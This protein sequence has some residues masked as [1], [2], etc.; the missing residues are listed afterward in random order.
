MER[1]GPGRSHRK[2]I[3]LAQLF[4]M[5]P[6]DAAAGRWL[7]RQRWPDGIACH[8]CGSTRVQTGAGHRSMPLRCREY[9]TCGKRFSVRTGTVMQSSKL[10]YQTWVIAIY[11]MVTNLKGVSSMKLHRDLGITQ[12]SAWHLAQ[13]LREAYDTMPWAFTGPVEVDETYLGGKERNKHESKRLH[14]GPVAGKIAVVGMK[15]RE[16][17]KVV[18]EVVNRTDADT[19]QGFVEDFTEPTATVYT[20]E[21]KAYTGL[22]RAHESVRHSAG[23]Y[24]RGEVHTN[25]MES[26]WAT[27]KRAYVGT[28][29]H[30][31]RKHAPRYVREFEGRH[32][33]RDRD[34]IGQ[35]AIMARGTQGKRLRY[36]DLIA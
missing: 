7:A 26:F 9:K 19:L 16:S 15:D 20:D 27:P 25:G 30:I 8:Y 31:S 35:M 33:T 12:K 5:F 36:R 18:A 11:L 14:A 2:G 6:N 24:V 4:R 3:S 22:S 34:T 17:G 28:Y 21:A 13:R 29:H 23:E 1:T 10:G 32:N